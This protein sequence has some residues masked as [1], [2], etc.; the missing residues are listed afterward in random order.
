MHDLDLR[1][2]STWDEFLPSNASEKELLSFDARKN[3]LRAVAAGK[4]VGGA[5][6]L[7]GVNPTTLSSTIRNA[8]K[9]A[10]DGRP[11]GWRAC[12]PK[13]VRGSKKSASGTFPLHAGPN[14]F[15]AFLQ[16][17]PEFE[18]MLLNY[19]GPIPGRNAPSTKFDSFFK[20]AKSWIKG[21]VP[22]D[23]YPAN[24][25]TFARRSVIGFLR[26][27]R[28]GSVFVDDGFDVEDS[29]ISSQL[30]EVFALQP[31]DWVQ[32]DGHKKDC[33]FNVE[34][35]DADGGQFLQKILSTWLIAGY[36]ALLRLCTSWKLSSCAC[37]VPCPPL[38]A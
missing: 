28:T 37:C 29:S 14:A 26:R 38:R 16:S 30:T 24:D 20:K 23:R 33:D 32:F 3:A 12:M 22:K 15:N 13:L 5:A 19:A 10:P 11:W 18:H 27:Q 36:M 21:N 35:T 17:A 31:A 6:D 8:M 1:A 25:P 2:I 34:G 7:Y 9:N 4:T